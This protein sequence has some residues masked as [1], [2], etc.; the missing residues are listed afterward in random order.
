MQI[1]KINSTAN[2]YASRTIS[3]KAKMS[4]QA[5]LKDFNKML[6]S[7][8]IM[9]TANLKPDGK[10]NFKTTV[11]LAKEDLYGYGTIPVTDADGYAVT[12]EGE[13]VNEAILDVLKSYKNED[14]YC[15]KNGAQSVLK[16]PSYLI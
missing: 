3:M 4:T 15:A 6:K 1:S 9:L 14:V 10:G 5:A 2:I 12:G 7:N 11:E 8:N 13:N 16:L